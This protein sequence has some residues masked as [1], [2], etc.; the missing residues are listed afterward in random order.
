MEQSELELLHTLIE[1][2]PFNLGDIVRVVDLETEGQ[3]VIKEFSLMREQ[4][5]VLLVCDEVTT[6]ALEK[7][8]RFYHQ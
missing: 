3:W 7:H 8:I 6:Y 4:L 1:S 2:S 5:C